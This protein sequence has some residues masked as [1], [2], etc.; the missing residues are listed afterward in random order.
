MRRLGS[1]LERS[2]AL[3]VFRSC[4]MWAGLPSSGGECVP[5][6][7]GSGRSSSRDGSES[8][9][10]R[11]SRAGSGFVDPRADGVGRALAHT[12]HQTTQN[13][14]LADFRG[15]VRGSG[16]RARTA[17]AGHWPILDTRPAR[18]DH[19]SIFGA[20]WGTRRPVSRILSTDDHLSEAHRCRCAHATYPGA[21]REQRSSGV[22]GRPWGRP[23]WSC[24]GWG[25]PSHP[26]HLGCWWSLTPPFHPYLSPGG[27]FSVAL[28]RGSPR[29]GVT[30]H[31][32]LRSP[33]FPQLSPAAIIW[34]S[35]PR[36]ILA[37][38][39]R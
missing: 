33:D 15:P 28:S 9:T 24:S 12:R 26:S 6:C 35:R 30:H 27:L 8:A 20:E 18:I 19:W 22:R 23:S 5:W 37:G 25:L 36:P 13:R 21:S 31:P 38:V 1:F 14:P 16:T 32:A 3:A 11:S 39:G 4:P 2:S 10:G 34:P 7:V 29:V 17:S